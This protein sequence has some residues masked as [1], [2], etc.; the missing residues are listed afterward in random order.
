MTVSRTSSFCETCRA[1]CLTCPR[2]RVVNG[3][4]N[5]V[6]AKLEAFSLG[7]AT[8]ALCWPFANMAEGELRCESGGA[9]VVKIAGEDYAVNGMASRLYPPIGSHLPRFQSQRRRMAR[10]LVGGAKGPILNSKYAPD[11]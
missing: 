5:Q 6:C 11:E 9:V 1:A 4:G 3:L 10:Y 8:L 2:E 7:F